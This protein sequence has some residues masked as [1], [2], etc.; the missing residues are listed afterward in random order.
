M[1]CGNF[2]LQDLDPPSPGGPSILHR[3]LI[4]LFNFLSILLSYSTFAGCPFHNKPFL[5]YLQR[6]LLVFNVFIP[7]ICMKFSS[8]LKFRPGHSKIFLIVNYMGRQLTISIEEIFCSDPGA[9]KEELLETVEIG[10][11][12]CGICGRVHVWCHTVS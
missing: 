12:V 7:T 10:C 5:S 4:I 2:P 8:Y 11:G 9:A 6:I 1:A 3:G